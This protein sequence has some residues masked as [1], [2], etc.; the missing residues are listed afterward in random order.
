MTADREL[1]QSAAMAAGIDVV[2][3]RVL[4][5]GGTPNEGFYA[6]DCRYGN[7]LT[8]PADAMR[9]LALL[10]VRGPCDV[11]VVEA[12]DSLYVLVPGVYVS[13]RISD[14]PS[15]LVALCRCVTRAAAA[16]GEAKGARA[17]ADA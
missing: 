17:S 12:F 13:E 14:H 1:L 5:F 15:T 9:L 11:G 4:G 8:D 2:W 7:P 3:R 10:S 6:P 16:I